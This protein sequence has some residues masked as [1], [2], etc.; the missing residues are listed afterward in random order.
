MDLL[1]NLDFNVYTPFNNN[2]SLNLTPQI[3][4]KG[5]YYFGL[6]WE[7]REYL[8]FEIYP[9]KNY[10][11][12]DPSS[13]IYLSFEFFRFYGKK[14]FKPKLIINNQFGFP[15]ESQN[16]T[17]YFYNKFK[18]G[19]SFEF[20]NFK[21]FIPSIYYVM[22]TYCIYNPFKVFSNYVG[23]EVNLDINIHIISISLNYEGIID[24][25]KDIY[26]SE[27]KWISKIDLYILLFL[28]N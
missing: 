24:A 23:F 10:F 21:I 11:T 5:N 18:A 20:N 13:Y 7:F 12:F 15:L 9:S 14:I 4:T 3:C 17:E 28:S 16:L 8:F 2:I 19:V 6:D 26:S 27:R 25:A 1:L 22:D